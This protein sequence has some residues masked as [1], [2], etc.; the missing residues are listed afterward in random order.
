M[1]VFIPWMAQI[2]TKFVPK[3]GFFYE[4]PMVLVTFKYP[5]YER[6]INMCDLWHENCEGSRVIK[7]TFAE[8]LLLFRV[9]YQNPFLQIIFGA[10][11][12]AWVR[13]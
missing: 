5:I 12:S 9:N 13:T 1:T 3:L 7:Y 4:L 11:F 2:I 10:F 8:C 6:N